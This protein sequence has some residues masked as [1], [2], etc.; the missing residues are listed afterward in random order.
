MLK[1]I[2][3]YVN[4]IKK[5]RGKA[6]NFEEL[7]KRL[8]KD[9]INVYKTILINGEW[10]IGKSYYLDNQ[11]PKLFNNFKI[12]KISLF[13]ITS[14][15]ELNLYFIKELNN[16]LNFL[17]NK[18]LNGIAGKEIEIWGFT[19]PLP[20]YT[21]DIVK[22]LKK[23]SKKEGNNIVVI[24]DDI[25][26]KS[27]NI[28][29]NE[30]MGFFENISN[31]D[32]LKLI[33]VANE[34]EIEGNDKK[35]FDTFKE[36]VI[37]K[38]YNVHKYSKNALDEILEKEK[39]NLVKN[40]DDEEKKSGIISTIKEFWKKYDIKNLRTLKKCI[41]FI[42]QNN[43]Y[44]NINDF[45]INQIQEIIIIEMAV[46][47][48]KIS[49]DY[50]EIE[51]SKESQSYFI[52]S[53]FTSF[54]LK[55]YFLGVNFYQKGELVDSMSEIYDDIDSD[56][57]ISTINSHYKE[58]NN[59][60][61]EEIDK[62]DNFYLSDKQLEERIEKFNK[63]YLNRVNND[64]DIN[65]WFKKFIYLYDCAENIGLQDLI[66]INSIEKTMDLY[67]AKL[68]ISKG[69]RGILSPFLLTNIGNEEFGKY[70]YNILKNKITKGYY[71]KLIEIVKNDY[72]Q[73]NY[74]LD[75]IGNLMNALVEKDL[76]EDVK[77]LVKNELREN[78]YFI[79]N[80]NETLN[81]KSWAYAHKIWE[82]MKFVT[83]KSDFKEITEKLIEKASKSGEYRIK[84]LNKYYKL[85]E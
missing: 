62:I 77:E 5:K 63:K 36:K 46:C 7:N 76:D 83:D 74:N 39:E 16:K 70:Y 35:V 8:G 79:P 18:Y 67:I 65:A 71:T 27:K 20:S 66:D 56:K 13:G 17:Y 44:L 30:L 3:F 78:D 75:N 38:T 37:E 42:K 80:L 40:I 69:V 64:L 41:N 23:I 72:K 48:E 10:G 33:L 24:I 22:K 32:D 12:I 9:L 11:M 19:L 1:S 84:F 2:A 68:D 34:N 82:M 61:D 15:Q 26:R 49:K 53:P 50:L 45:T 85:F 51:A 59:A 52:N 55:K 4:I 31:I 6:M 73:V 21:S 28:D 58:Q 81:E 57:N 47:I 14:M 43:E 25:E 60:S 29:I 54:L